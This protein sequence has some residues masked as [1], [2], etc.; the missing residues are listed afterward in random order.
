MCLVVGGGDTA[1]D[2]ALDLLDLAEEITIIHR[3]DRFRALD[4]NVRKMEESKKINILLNTE[5]KEIRGTDK[6]EEAVLYNNKTGEEKVI[7]VDKIIPCSWS[8]AKHRAFP[9]N[10]R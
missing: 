10:R 1:V 5:L 3:R 8:Q 2:T 7:K 4:D 9:E 6:V